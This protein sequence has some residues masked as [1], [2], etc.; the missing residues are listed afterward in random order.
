MCSYWIERIKIMKYPEIMSRKYPGKFAWVWPWIPESWIPESVPWN[1]P[2]SVTVNTRKLNPWK[3]PLKVSPE[4]DRD[5]PKVESLKMSPEKL[6]V[7]FPKWV[8]Y[9]FNAD[10]DT[11]H[12]LQQ[13]TN[14]GKQHIWPFDPSNLF[15]NTPMTTLNTLSSKPRYQLA[16]SNLV[17]WPGS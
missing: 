17:W 4:S 1:C 2:L 8:W 6:K 15:Q 12:F 11:A 16:P 7:V 9:E 13:N 14:F 5:Y 10:F 3:S